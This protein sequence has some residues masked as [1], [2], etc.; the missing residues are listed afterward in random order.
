MSESN[1]STEP[2][3]PAS[4]TNPP[5]AR[6][7][8]YNVNDAIDPEPS[9]TAHQPNAMGPDRALAKDG[10]DSPETDIASSTPSTLPPRAHPSTTTPAA[11]TQEAEE[12]SD[13]SDVDEAILSA[14]PAPSRRFA[15]EPSVRNWT[16]KQAAAPKYTPAPASE[17]E[18]EEEDGTLSAHPG[19]SHPNAAAAA[20][21]G[22]RQPSAS[23][24]AAI[25][26]EVAQTA[27]EARAELEA[28]Q[29]KRKEGKGEGKERVGWEPQ[30][31][32]TTSMLKQPGS[33][34]GPWDGERPY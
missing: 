26:R 12:E 7:H 1:T 8:A 19:L 31:Y 27:A 13:L 18:E 23:L 22:Q 14:A 2:H 32:D 29:K 28:R 16:T 20:T 15:A 10:T 33:R 6:L 21:T 17:D 9:L 34:F 25:A 30:P 3:S 4:Q 24:K 5:P 11:P